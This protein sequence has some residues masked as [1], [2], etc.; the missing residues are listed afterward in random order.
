[1]LGA[2]PLEVLLRVAEIRV[3]LAAS[4]R[5]EVE[6]IRSRAAMQAGGALGEGAAARPASAPPNLIH[7]QQQMQ[8]QQMPSGVGVG[9][10]AAPTPSSSQAASAPLLLRIRGGMSVPLATAE[11][12]LA[13]APSVPPTLRRVHE[14]ALPVMMAAAG[15][16][17]RGAASA[18]QA[19]D[20]P[21]ASGLRLEIFTRFILLCT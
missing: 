11:A 7:Q 2:R 1:M 10:D 19:G 17:A 4:A 12:A 15:A 20:G 14:G 21:P 5:A 13:L 8:Q 9:F 18:Q 6:G 3:R 16:L